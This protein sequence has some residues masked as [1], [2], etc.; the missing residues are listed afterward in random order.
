MTQL[1]VRSVLLPQ[2]SGCW[3]GVC[4]ALPVTSS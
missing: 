3:L 2:L 1:G 4:N